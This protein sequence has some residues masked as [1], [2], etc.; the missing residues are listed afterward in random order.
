LQPQEGLSVE[1]FVS[2]SGYE[3]QPVSVIGGLDEA[4]N[5]MGMVGKLKDFEKKRL[6]KRPDISIVSNLPLG[7]LDFLFREEHLR[8]GI[9]A[10]L[11]RKLLN[12]INLAPTIK[13]FDPGSAIE[14]DDIREGRQTY[15]ILATITNGQMAILIACA[16]CEQQAKI[17]SNQVFLDEMNDLYEQGG[18]SDL[19]DI[20]TI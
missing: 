18:D 2:V 4:T 5:V 16:F 20:Y 11:N 14:K 10:Y 7:D 13:L 8:E 1:F 6:E 19:Y 17:M 15:S 9:T 3:G 12:T